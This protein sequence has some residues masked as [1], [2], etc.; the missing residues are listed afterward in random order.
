MTRI[1]AQFFLL[2]LTFT[3]CKEEIGPT[4]FQ[5]EADPPGQ[6]YK[7]DFHVHATGAS[8]DTGGD[9]WPEAIKAKALEHNL[10]FVVLTDHSNSTGSDV[11]TRDEKPTLFN[12]GS[13]F[14]YWEKARELSETDKFLMICGNEISPV[15][16]DGTNK[17]TGHIGC[18][19]RSL[20]NFDTLTPFID[21]PKGA[22]TG[23]NA[24]EQAI[25]RG[26]FTII[27]HP[28][29]LAK[30]IEYDW[31]NM[32]YDAIEIWNG[33]IGYDQMDQ[34][35]HRAWICDLLAGKNTVAIGASDCHR[36]HTVVPGKGLDPALGYPATAIFAQSLTWNSIMENLQKGNTYIF[37]GNSQLLIDTYNKNGKR[38]SVDFEII[39]LRGKADKHLEN[40]VLK[41]IHSTECDDPRPKN[42]P[43]K[44]TETILF[45]QQIT[46]GESF[47]IRI[48]TTAVNGVYSAVLL[49]G[50]HYGALSKAAVVD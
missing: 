37:E 29:S 46:A 39:R 34:Y 18:I 11:N 27:N 38:S 24:L 41:L 23:G 25:D 14:P 19:P 45:E 43:P 1:I 40:P 32:E 6:W 4:T 8:N 13:E 7:G 26:C 42:N 17:A 15:A 16:E 5:F 3:S 44:L 48:D 2:L 31:T 30:W 47:D 35:A 10:D 21:R 36:V 49:D 28:Y 33:T 22:V 50:L 12:M 20:E 9:S